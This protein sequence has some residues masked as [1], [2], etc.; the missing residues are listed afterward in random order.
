[1]ERLINRRQQGDLGEAS[2][3]EWLTSIGAAVL[4]PLGHSPNFDLVAGIGDRLLRIQVKTSVCRNDT[5]RGDCRYKV[6]LA[7][8]GGN[9]SWRGEVK[10]FDATAVDALF[11]LVGDGRR[12]FIPAA[13]VEAATSLNLGGPLYSEFEIDQGRP[14]HPLVY[15]LQARSRIEASAGERRSG[16]AGPDCKSGGLSL[17]GFESHLPHQ[18]DRDDS[19]RCPFRKS[20]RTRMS[21]AHQV[22]IPSTPFREAELAVG[23]RLHVTADG[24]GR[25]ILKRI[26]I[27]PNPFDEAGE[28]R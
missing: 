3:I 2:A 20:E 25:V 11:V 24:A 28:A 14:L 26:E 1:V 7:T 12:W 4:L 5:S 23:D 13:A 27:P 22:T 15:G 18:E 16:R 10:S 17:S 21:T 9:Q 19:T 8:N 6:Q